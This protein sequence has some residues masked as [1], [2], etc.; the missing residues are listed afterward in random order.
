MKKIL[1]ANKNKPTPCIKHDK[2]FWLS[3]WKEM[4]WQAEQIVK[5]GASPNEEVQK[6]IND[7]HSG[8]IASKEQLTDF[9]LEYIMSRTT[10]RER[11]SPHMKFFEE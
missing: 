11:D 9:I 5:I 8:V 4:K 10:P 1:S 3:Q 2:I 7:Y 6:M